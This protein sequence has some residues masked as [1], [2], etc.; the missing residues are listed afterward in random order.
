MAGGKIDIT[1]GYTN[2]PNVIPMIDILLVLLIIFMMQVA[3]QR[4]AMDVQLP[5]EQQMEADQA[6]AA[7]TNQIV[8]ELG[9][10]GSYSIN[11]DTIPKEALDAKL[12]EIYDRRPAKLMFLKAARSRPYRDVIEAMDIA[13]GAGVQVIGFTPPEEKE[14][15]GTQGDS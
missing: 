10:D 6:E 5:P 15:Q 12:H 14:E 13:R 4:K 2:E 1:G 9:A 7:Q 8:M 11:A 3:Q